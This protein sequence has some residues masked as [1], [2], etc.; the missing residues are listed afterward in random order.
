MELICGLWVD[1]CRWGQSNMT[2]GTDCHLRLK[3]TKREEDAPAQARLAACEGA[4]V[5]GSMH[6]E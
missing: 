4:G 1:H 3:K 2:C 6:G 5:V